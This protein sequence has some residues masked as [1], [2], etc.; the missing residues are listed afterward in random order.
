VLVD[1]E[2]SAPDSVL[3][4]GQTVAWRRPPWEEPEAPTF[5]AILYEDPDLLAVAKPAG[6]PT[7]PAGGFLENTLL[8]RVQRY[9]PDAHPLHR[10]G[11]WTSGLVLFARTEQSRS[12]MAGRWRTGKVA[13][14]YRALASGDPA[15]GEFTVDRP[16][17]PVPHDLLGTVHAASSDGKPSRTVVR[18]LEKREGSFLAEAGIVT[19][20]PHQIRIHLAAAGHPLV[21]DPLYGPGGIPAKRSTALPGDPGYHLHAALL[22]FDHPASGRPVE[23]RCEPPPILRPGTCR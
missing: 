22:R 18:V 20:R 21:G 9:D 13:K 8:R 17:G 15:M 14:I 4:Q 3:Q 11:R 19:G 6:L 7:L 10:L 16:I 1:G 12:V 2:R 23:L 5:F